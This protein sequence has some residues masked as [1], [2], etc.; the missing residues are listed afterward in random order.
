MWHAIYVTCY[1][2][3]VMF[4]KNLLLYTTMDCEIYIHV[5]TV[6]PRKCKI[7]KKVQESRL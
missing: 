5:R 1:S 6:M 4:Q 7:S 2:K 3:N